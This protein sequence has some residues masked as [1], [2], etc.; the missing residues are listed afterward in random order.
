MRVKSRLIGRQGAILI[1]TVIILGF[2]AVLGMSLVALLYSRTAYSQMQL[3][4][5]KALYL[6]EA[7][8]SKAIWE[9]RFELD[10]DGDG[11]GNIAPT[12]LSDGLFWTRHNFQTSTITSTGEVEKVRRTVQIKYSAI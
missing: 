3:N 11:P 9:M 7:G 12:K 10:P 6:A 2:L 4:R 5:L 1:T 8:I